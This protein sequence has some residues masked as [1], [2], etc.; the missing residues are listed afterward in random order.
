[1]IAE[2]GRLLAESTDIMQDDIMVISVIDI[3]KCVN[4]RR[5]FN[6][7]VWGEVPDI[8]WEKV[9]V[10]SRRARSRMLRMH[11]LSPFYVS[12]VMKRAY[13]TSVL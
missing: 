1:M 2:N 12:C 11:R 8:V 5:K 13:L 4:D 3:E 10:S 9:F 6:S 7:D